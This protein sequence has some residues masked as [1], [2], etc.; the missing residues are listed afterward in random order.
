MCWDSRHRNGCNLK[1]E[2]EIITGMSG[3]PVCISHAC[4]MYE[5]VLG[6]CRDAE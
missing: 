5:A 1:D 3:V 2:E 6:G 4:G